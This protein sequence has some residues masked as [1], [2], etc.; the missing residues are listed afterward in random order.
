MVLSASEDS[1]KNTN[2]IALLQET[3]KICFV[4]TFYTIETGENQIIRLTPGHFVP[5][6]AEN[7][8]RRYKQAQNVNSRRPYICAI[9][10]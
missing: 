5:V 9:S 3:S 10:G 7:G 1:P 6:L 2:N 8:E 4:A